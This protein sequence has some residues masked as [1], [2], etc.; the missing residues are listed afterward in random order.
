MRRPAW[1][2]GLCL[3]L[4]VPLCARAESVL[5]PY[6]FE[7][8][9]D[10][11]AA[12]QSASVTLHGVQFDGNR[13]FS[14]EELA[15]LIAGYLGRPLQS[16]DLIGLRDAVTGHY[17]DAGYL[18]SGATLQH[19]EEGILHVQ[20]QENPLTA[21]RIYSD[22]Q[23]R[24]AWLA[25]MLNARDKGG[26]LNVFTLERQLQLLTQHPQIRSLDAR[27]QPGAD[28]GQAVL[29]LQARETSPWFASVSLN[30]HQSTAVGSARLDLVAQ[31]TGLLGIGDALSLQVSGAEGLAEAS[32]GWAVPL[33]ARGTSI[34]LSLEAAETE[35][36]A[37]PFDDLDI[38]SE[39]AAAS[40]AIRHRF[41]HDLQLQV[42]GFFGTE[43]RRSKTFLLGQGFSFVAGPREGEV[44]LTLL[45]AGVEMLWRNQ[46]NVVASRLELIR[47]IDAFGAMSARA[48][49][50]DPESLSASAQLQWGRRLTPLNSQILVRGD[51]QLADG[52]LFGVLQRPV[53]GRRSVRGYRENT[54][55]RD[56][57]LGLSV[58]WRIPLWQRPDG[59]PRL[60]LGPFVD[61]SHS[62]NVDRDELGPTELKS[63]GLG[64]SW[65]PGRRWWLELQWGHALDR[66]D[67]PGEYSLQNDGLHMNLQWTL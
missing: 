64:V 17:V 42:D 6:E 23:F 12:P 48:G 34:A 4:L 65:R 30:N 61:W 8:V 54:L 45:R 49:A 11:S 19:V 43:I 46:R 38:E 32:L 13:V 40:I 60:E 63:V 10:A 41:W 58:E 22:G 2:G 21:L 56:A 26:P 66:L 35:I 20:V 18:S 44:E 62:W 15:S 55:V 47:G 33:N 57:V 25:K 28:P 5:P 37:R 59:Q 67:Y 29:Q 36:V 9:P 50:P 31:R 3:L 24:S 1:V 27:I 51:V 14:D 7:P 16:I 39:S 53:G 52:P